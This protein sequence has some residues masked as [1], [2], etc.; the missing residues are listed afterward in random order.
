MP[1]AID[2]AAIRKKLPMGRSDAEKKARDALFT[3]F[4]PNSNGYLSL[5]EVDKGCRDVLGLYEIFEAKP[6]IMR[7]FQAAKCANNKSN[8]KGSHGPDYI[9]RIEFRLLFVYL[10]QYFEIW[11][12]F[13][14]IDSSDDHRVSY[15]EFV[16][17]LPKIA[18]WGVKVKD[19][20]AA[21]R[22]IDKDGGGMILFDEF[23]DWA[24]K[25]QL[26]IEDDDDFEDPAL[27]VPV[28]QVPA[29]PKQAGGS[30]APATAASPAKPSSGNWMDSLPVDEEVKAVLIKEKI[31]ER[32]FKLLTADD[33]KDLG[34]PLGAR[35][36]LLQEIEARK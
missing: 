21:F 13:D 4:D 1:R 12:M 30:A 3:Q 33:L 2:W 26:D 35:K 16:A 10:R 22:E 17:A 27:T 18:T 15:D 32:A 8:K 19:P 24:L 23:A 14:E 29:Q 28:G 25:K 7:A 36:V 6:V 20:K 11:Q 9:E 5:A 34:L 31:D